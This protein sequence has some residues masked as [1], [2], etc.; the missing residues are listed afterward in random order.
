M[1]EKIIWGLN[2][3][4]NFGVMGE[5]TNVNGLRVG[6]VVDIDGDDCIVIYD[7]AKRRYSVLGYMMYS[8]EELRE[9]QKNFFLIR[10][11][12]DKINNQNIADISGFQITIREVIDN[13][14]PIYL[15]D[16]KKAFGENIKLIIE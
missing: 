2:S 8:L 14:R 4:E 3:F 12:F 16:I 11:T 15:S 10:Y 13:K 9:Q 1:S 7:S 5:E 6:D